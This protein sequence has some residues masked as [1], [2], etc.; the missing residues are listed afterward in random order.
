LRVRAPFFLVVLIA[1]LVGWA[2]AHADETVHVDTDTGRHVFSVELADT[3][4]LR[5]RGLMYRES[6]ARDHGMLFDFERDQEVAMWMQ[7][8]YIPLDMIFILSDG[9]VHRIARDTTPFSTET[10]ASQGAVRA[11]LEVNAGVAREI[12]LQPG[13]IVRHR[14]FSNAD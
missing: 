11:V 6:M 2:Q 1:V 13:D 14:I 8:T 5:A 7:N 4:Q 12:G 3:P 10:I 9:T